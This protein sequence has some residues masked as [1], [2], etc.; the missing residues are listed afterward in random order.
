MSAVPGKRKSQ[1]GLALA[2]AGCLLMSACGQQTSHSERVARNCQEAGKG[3]TLFKTY[4]H[5]LATATDWQKVGWIRQV[6]ITKWMACRHQLASH[7]PIDDC[8]DKLSYNIKKE[9]VP[10]KSAVD[11]CIRLAK[12]KQ[13]R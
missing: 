7:A 12:R 10:F 5:K 11:R 13:G 1:L 6:S 8:L 2:T 3:E 9:V 4:A